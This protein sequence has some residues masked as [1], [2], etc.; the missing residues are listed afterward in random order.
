[1][2]EKDGSR[3]YL[4]LD[5]GDFVPREL[6]FVERDF[7]LL[8][9]AQ[10]PELLWSQDEQSVPGAA[11]SP[12]RTT[13]AMNVLL[14]SKMLISCGSLR[15]GAVRRTFGSSGG[16]Y[17]TIQSTAGMSRPLAATSVQSRMPDSALQNWKNVVVRFVCFCLPCATEICILTTPSKRSSSSQL[18]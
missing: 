2:Q 3:P 11:L 13:D 7:G 17:C 10:E 5:V 14:K 4:Q 12:S 6:E 9:V 18:T 15:S 1:M 16:S 8:Q